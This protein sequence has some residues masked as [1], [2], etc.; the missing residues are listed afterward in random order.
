MEQYLHST[1][2]LHNVVLDDRRGKL[3]YAR[4]DFPMCS[5]II[6]KDATIHNLFIST[7]C[8]T[9]FGGISTHHQ[10]LI[11]LYLQYL[12]LLGQLLLPATFTTSSSNGPSNARYCRYSDVRS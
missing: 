7:N 4:Y 6:Q 10:E 8:C 11:L 9:C 2:C 12:P 5:I 1:M 3:I